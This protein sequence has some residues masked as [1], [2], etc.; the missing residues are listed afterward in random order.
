M[1]PNITYGYLRGTFGLPY[2]GY[3][4]RPENVDEIVLQASNEYRRM[5]SILGKYSDV[6]KWMTRHRSTVLNQSSMEATF[7]HELVIEVFT[8]SS[9]WTRMIWGLD[10]L[11]VQ[12]VIRIARIWD[13]QSNA[14]SQF[15]PVLKLIA[16]SGISLFEI[17]EHLQS[18]QPEQ[19]KDITSDK[20]VLNKT[21][22][23]V[24]TRDSTYSCGSDSH[25][26][27]PYECHR[28]LPPPYHN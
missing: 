16:P 4:I 1:K 17:C 26:L 27:P 23:R 19:T 13:R 6:Q 2:G 8:E 9:S 15:H 22:A 5:F 14:S 11:N 28:R 25:G 10:S 3:C 12:L 24:S 20:Y 18:M 21:L 7:T